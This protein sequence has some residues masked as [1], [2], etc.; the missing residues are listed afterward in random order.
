LNEHIAAAA[1]CSRPE[2]VMTEGLELNALWS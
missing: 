1:S 2:E